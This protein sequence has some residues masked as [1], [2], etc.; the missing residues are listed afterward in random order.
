MS[1]V[2]AIPC[3]NTTRYFKSRNLLD[4]QRYSRRPTHSQNNPPRLDSFKFSRGEDLN[5]KK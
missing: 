3:K 2:K 4:S 5:E 1:V